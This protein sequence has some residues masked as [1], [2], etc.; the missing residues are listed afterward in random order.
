MNVE[1][2]CPHCGHDHTHQTEVTVSVRDHE[3]SETGLTAIISNNNALNGNDY[4]PTIIQENKY[5]GY[6]RRYCTK[7]KM[8][9]EQ[10]ERTF[11]H[12]YSQR[13]GTTLAWIE[14]NG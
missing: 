13:T 5:N 9:C 4:Q 1:V 14:L 8:I 10:C 12:I 7:I 3:D 2:I 6:S 11:S